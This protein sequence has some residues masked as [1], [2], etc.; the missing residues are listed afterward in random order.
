MSGDVPEQAVVDFLSPVPGLLAG[1]KGLACPCEVPDFLR[2][3]MHV[4]GKADTAIADQSEPQ[5]FF[6]H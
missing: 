1:M 6:A 4:D 2:D 3:S 5:F